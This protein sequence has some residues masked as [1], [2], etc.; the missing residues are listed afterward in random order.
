MLLHTL[1]V[2]RPLLIQCTVKSRSLHNVNF[3]VSGIT[4]S[5]ADFGKTC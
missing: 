1:L 2:V 5:A 3:K 4:K